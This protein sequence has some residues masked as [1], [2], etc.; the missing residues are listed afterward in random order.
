MV[1]KLREFTTIAAGFEKTK[2]AVARAEDK[3][4]IEALNDCAKMG[5]I[6]PV[7]LG[8]E[9]KI[10]S[11]MEE[12]KV[13]EDWT[14]I[15]AE[16]DEE[17]MVKI[18]ELIE[19]GEVK[20]IVKGLINSS[21]FMRGV[22]KS[23]AINKKGFLHHMAAYELPQMEK[24]FFVSDSG[25]N[26]LP[27]QEEKEKILV[28]CVEAVKSVGIAC[29]KV[30]VLS[31]NEVVSEKMPSTVHADYLA[32]KYTSSDC[33]VE[34]PI[35]FDVAISKDAAE[36]KGLSSQVAGEVDLF[37]FPN[38]EAGNI[39]G[40]SWLYFNN[41]KWCGVVLGCEVPIVMGSRSDT[42]ENK[43]NSIA[44]AKLLAQNN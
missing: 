22:L 23:K 13:C 10:K 11:L 44:L 32:K 36:H 31:A 7:V 16:T 2:M 5:F 25:I 21:V 28:N 29:P 42:K 30:A 4:V 43:I 15:H 41:A 39:V 9:K 27:T 24:I 3:G 8:D 17:V 38:I 14:V 6:E 37:I 18:V 33:I 12:V 34:G 35:A 19:S 40:K 20:G 26:I 1:G